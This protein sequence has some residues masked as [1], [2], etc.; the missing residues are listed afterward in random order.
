VI[1]AAMAV[2]DRVGTEAMTMRKIATELEVSPMAIYHYVADRDEILDS[3]VDRVFAEIGV[4]VVGDP[5]RAQMERRARSARAALQRHQWAITLMD[6]RTSPGL[7][8]IRH[9]DAVAGCLRV[10]GMSVRLT[11][12]AVA[13]LDMVIYG[14]A[15]QE[16]ALPFAGGDEVSEVVGAIM[17]HVPSDEFPYIAELATELVLQPG[18]DFGDEFDYALDLVLDAIEERFRVERS[19]IVD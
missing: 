11:A 18:Y 14:F 10:A 3:M 8:T 16:A 1:D 7:E 4:P 15:V 9:N 12:H 17:D 5:W 13:V 2:A 6:S 19:S